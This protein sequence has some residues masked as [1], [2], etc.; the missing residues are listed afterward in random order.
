[1]KAVTAKMLTPVVGILVAVPF[2]AV[3]LILGAQAVEVSQGTQDDLLLAALALAAA[4][5][6]FVNGMGRRTD[7]ERLTPNKVV[8]PGERRLARGASTIHLGF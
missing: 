7:R 8:Q 5:V 6:S 2:F 3:A 1:M 4:V